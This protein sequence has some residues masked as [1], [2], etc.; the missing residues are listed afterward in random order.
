MLIEGRW[1]E[2]RKLAHIVVTRGF[3]ENRP[4]AETVL[5]SLNIA[6]GDYEAAWR[7]IF[8]LLPDGPATKP[9]EQRLLIALDVQRLAVELSLAEDDLPK[10]HD[11]LDV[12]DTW[13]AWSGARAGIAE[14]IALRASFYR[15]VGKDDA[16]EEHANRAL[17][18]ASEPRQPLAMEMAHRELGIQFHKK[19]EFGRAREHLQ[20]ALEIATAC[21]A[22]YLQALRLVDLAA[23]E[24]SANSA[25]L[26]TDYLSQAIGRLRDLGAKPALRRATQLADQIPT[27]STPGLIDDRPATEPT[28]PAGLTERELEVL[29][30]LASG[31]SNREMATALDL[32]IRTIERHVSNIY[33]KIDAHNRVDA[34]AF[35]ISYELV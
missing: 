15:L 19:S 12:H 10:A 32:S 20:T 31:M 33:I 11:W 22:E 28:I 27:S 13:T 3:F 23:L 26:A 25:S 7:R 8:K 6:Q 2:A 1:S 16:A 18:E 4:R 35:A 9:G 21:S 34:T 29:Q 17:A 24:L 5:I 14:S 30:Y